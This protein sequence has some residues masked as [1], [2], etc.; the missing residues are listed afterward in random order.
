MD[1]P[2][3]CAV[4]CSTKNVEMCEQCHSIWYCS[5][6]CIE[7]D[8]DLHEPLCVSAKALSLPFGNPPSHGHVKYVRAILLREEERAPKVVY[9]SVID[10]DFA[11]GGTERYIDVNSFLKF[12]HEDQ[13]VLCCD[14]LYICYNGRTR[15]Y[16]PNHLQLHYRGFYE[17]W[18]FAHTNTA[19]RYSALRQ[20]SRDWVGPLLLV[21]SLGTDSV[22]GRGDFLDITLQDYRDFLAYFLMA[23]VPQDPAL[24]DPNT[25]LNR[26][27]NSLP[28]HPHDVRR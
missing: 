21:K 22:N 24:E 2:K 6:E 25:A 7:I 19:L 17:I 11:G 12:P 20:P 23:G 3:I 27:R 13:D 5:E 1:P 15:R 9:V 26:E 8:W 4:C 28:I 14:K 16:L 10:R 18:E